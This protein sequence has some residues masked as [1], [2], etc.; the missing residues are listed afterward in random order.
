M[1]VKYYF[2]LD[3]VVWCGAEKSFLALFIHYSEFKALQL[4]SGE[5]QMAREI[6]KSTTSL[7][8]VWFPDPLAFRSGLGNL[9]SLG[10]VWCEEGGTEKEHTSTVCLH[11]SPHSR[12]QRH[13][14]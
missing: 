11:R 1:A 10:A 3:G 12:H 6:V 5:L 4:S 9:V 8:A 13:S 7:G 14:R 2:T